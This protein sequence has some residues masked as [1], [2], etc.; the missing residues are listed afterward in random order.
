MK[1]AQFQIPN[2]SRK[3][4]ED[5]VIEYEWAGIWAEH[6][7]SDD[8][9]HEHILFPNCPTTSNAQVMFASK[10]SNLKQH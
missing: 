10:D 8:M 7:I 2:Q 1:T 3:V 5:L 4:I 6:R 9:M